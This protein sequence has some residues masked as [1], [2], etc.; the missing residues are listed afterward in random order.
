MSRI[1]QVRPAGAGHET[2]CVLLAAALI[3]TLAA[4][5]VTLR[6]ERQ[7]EQAIAVHQLDARRD[8]SAA[9]QGIHTD[10][11][12]AADEIRALREETGSAADAQAL[13]AEG[14]PP[15][16][17][18][19]SSQRRGRHQW[20]LLDNGAYLGHSQDPSLAGTFLLIPAADADTRP[21]IWLRRDSSA[22]APDDLATPLLIAAGWRQVVS[23]YDAGVTRQHRH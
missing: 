3:V 17:D 9:E 2:L 23:H 22:L 5:V 6:G 14:L 21:E 8:L 18:D 1:Q 11:W 13:A 15:F 19:A 16:V 20:R 10:L 7:D 12:V 4:A